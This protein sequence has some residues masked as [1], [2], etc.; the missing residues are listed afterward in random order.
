MATQRGVS[1]RASPFEP[2]E[3]R[4]L[5]RSDVVISELVANNQSGLFDFF[6]NDSDWFEIHNRESSHVN[7][8]GWHVTDDL[9]NLTKWQ[10]PVTTILAPD[11]RRVVFASEQDL[12]TAT[13]E[14]HTNFRLSELGE[15]LALVD[16]DG[17]VVDS[18]DPMFPSQARDVSYG[19][20]EGDVTALIAAGAPASAFVP[21]NDSLGNS[22]TGANE[23]F[24]ENN[25]IS[26]TSGI[27]YETGSVSE[28][29]VPPV[30]YWTF[31]AL[32]ADGKIAPDERGMYHG[33][34]A[35]ATLTTEHA[36]RF[37]EA[38]ALDGDDDYVDV[39]VVPEL[40]NPAAM[41]VSL[42]FRHTVD[43][44]GDVDDMNHQVNNVLIGH[45]S[46]TSNDT[47]EIG[48][49]DDFIE[50][51]LD[52]EQLGGSVAPIREQAPLQN[53]VWHHLVMT[54]DSQ[55][56]T[57]VKLYL[58][59]T[60]EVELSEWGG[61]ISDSGDSP[62]SI[63]LARPNANAWGDFEGLIDDVAIWD[64]A[65]DGAQ[66]SAL[67]SGTSPLLL[68]GFDSL[69]GL[70][71]AAAML[72]QNSSAYMRMPF[73]VTDPADMDM[74][75]LLL[76]YDDAFVAYINGQEVA[77]A[78]FTGVPHWNSVADSDRPNI[79]ALYSAV[80]EI[81]VQPGILQTGKN[82]LA[83]QGMNATVASDRFL[84]LPELSVIAL[85]ERPYS[86]MRTPTPGTI[87]FAGSVGFAQEP[88]LSVLG[89]M[90][91]DSFHLELTAGSLDAEIRYTTNGSLPSETSN[92][93]IGP[94][95]ING[96]MQIRAITFRPDYIRSEIVSE[97]YTKLG[98]D[99]VDYQGSGQA[100]NSQVPLVVVNTFGRSIIDGIFTN[101]SFA[102]FDKQNGSASLANDV[103][104]ESRA[105]LKIRGRGSAGLPKSPYALE[106]RQD[107][108]DSDRSISL[109]VM[110]AEADWVFYGPYMT[111]RSMNRNPLMFD[112]SNQVGRYASRTAYVEVFVNQTGNLTFGDYVGIY[113]LTEK[114][115]RDPERVDVDKL[116]SPMVNEPDITGGYIFKQDR[117]DQG[118]F[119]IA[120]AGTI[121]AYVEPK[122]IE[123]LQRPEQEAYLKNYLNDFFS[124][125]TSSDFTHPS[126]GQNYSEL[127]DIVAAVD[128]H[129]LNE[130]ALNVDAF[131]LSAFWH[132][133]RNGKLQA[134]PIWDLDLSIE[135]TDDRDDDPTTWYGPG[136]MPHFWL[137]MFSDL[138]FRQAYV[139]R[140]TEFRRDMFSDENI[141]DTIDRL[142]S[143]L[144][145]DN[146][147]TGEPD[148]V[149]RNFTRWPQTRPRRSS[150]YNSGKLN[151]TFRGELEHQKVW[152]KERTA[153]LDS[154]FL[155][156]P[157]F[158]KT[159][160]LFKELQTL[161]ITVPAGTT[162]YYTIDGTDPRLPG[163]G[164]SPSATVYNE[165]ILISDTL[166]I[167]AR[168][169]D[170]GYNV[171]VSTF[172]QPVNDAEAWS[173]S[174]ATVFR[175]GS[176][177]VT[178]INYHPHEPTA[179]ELF[180]DPTFVD[181]DFEFLELQNT[182]Q[183]ILTL[184]GMQLN[185]GIDFDFS[186]SN[187]T[188]LDPGDYALVVRNM[189]AFVTR[190]GAGLREVV[191]GQY[192][193]SLANGGEQLTLVD[194]LNHVLQRFDYDDQ[195][196]WSKLPD[197]FGGTLEI[198]DPLQDLDDAVNWRAS[199]EF[200]GTPGTAGIGV[201]ASVVINEVLTNPS[202]GED[203][204]ELYN[205][206]SA[207]VD[208]SGW[209]LSDSPGNLHRFVF[210]ANST[211]PAGSFLVLVRN[212]IGF[213]LD[214][215]KGDDVVLVQPDALGNP[216]QFIDH[217]TFGAAMSDESFGRWPNESGNVYP[218]LSSTFGSA[219]LGPRIGP[220]VVGEIMYNPVSTVDDPRMLEFVEIYN[221]TSQSVG[222]SG[223]TLEGTGFEFPSDA[224]IGPGQTLVL[225][226]FNPSTDVE[227][228]SAF[229]ESYGVTLLSNLA[230][231]LG[232]YPGQLADGGEQLTL[233]R[234]LN[235]P[236]VSPVIEDQVR[237]DNTVPWPTSPDGAGA[238]LQRTRVDLW[239]NDASSWSS[240]A[241]TPGHMGPGRIFAWN[242]SLPAIGEVGKLNDLTHHSQTVTLAG[243]YAN[244]VV[245][246][247]PSSF[248][249]TDPVVVRVSNVQPNQFDISVV[250]P[251]NQNG[252]HNA[253]ETVSYLVLEA[254]SH[255]LRDGTHLEVGT[256]TTA[257]TVG[258]QLVAPNW[259]T[260]HLTTTFSEPPVV[261]S[262]VLTLHGEA[263]L[264]TRQR[265]VL[266]H[267]FELALEQEELSATQHVAET[268]GYLAI[269]GG[270]GIW[271]GMLFEAATT[272]S[273]FTDLFTK[274]EFEQE[275]FT[276][277]SFLA[278]LA[279]HNG[280]DVGHL[281]FQ[282]LT[283]ESVQLKVDEDT[284]F[285]PET[286][287]S[288]SESVMY[289]T[290][291]GEGLVTAMTKSV[292]DGA[293]QSLTLLVGETGRMIDVDVSFELVHTRPEDLVLSLEAPDGT[294][295]QLLSNVSGDGNVSR[296]VLDDEALKPISTAE[297]PWFGR[298]HPQ[299]R[300]RDFVGQE[301]QGAWTLHV[302]DEN[303]NG[304]AGA[305]I[306]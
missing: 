226:P 91:A 234:G 19:L 190:Y 62:L 220:L 134:G 253:A 292:V 147:S 203:A 144:G 129:L 128:H 55:N 8:E 221:P 244:P 136:N 181:S 175:V 116:S 145:S 222:L 69:I 64:V 261:L 43:H 183:T 149:T 224:V 179:E 118:E 121:F 126:T 56:L 300:L 278:S 196:E 218:M 306:T 54:Y 155:A 241:P 28:T 298:F 135:S 237:F 209:W 291:E 70:D 5:L 303:T 176:I 212:D 192:S 152:L 20:E 178:E 148:S 236:E 93:Y 279:S 146:P 77:R 39:G 76:N 258:P 123:I 57:E 282:D 201:L 102:V 22:W 194:E 35:G 18:F 296:F 168:S 173:G 191:A 286:G 41:S 295:V 275:Y 71:L 249:G 132:K 85:P 98:A 58:D 114:I 38:L 101:I 186:S 142:A 131:R 170:G 23:P 115:K 86:F 73:Y 107:H 24:D 95:V 113:V 17:A 293:T 106:L 42:W 240:G 150:A 233:R 103:T 162:V 45:S 174:A 138:E 302:I 139:D 13:G 200:S 87:N 225:V 211:I 90:F 16:P 105:A 26:G 12:V 49:E 289:M 51:Y 154:L 110:P 304:D 99:L 198:I 216:G 199:T 260:V 285:D 60:L 210:P 165:P 257:A 32:E 158:D 37:G 213:G 219:N 89:G 269:D 29:I 53:N 169:F 104:V 88:S 238:S 180:L 256:V 34:V 11:E 100:F 84:I 94:I 7:L 193:G 25:W 14:F 229:E 125:V 2:L 204:F 287:H 264:S 195:D 82:I 122:E 281:R 276:T 189:S 171:P 166:R 3:D 248:V 205:P 111:D 46:T 112:L 119:G 127:M 97:T 141:V 230:S 242:D 72:N 50:V 21:S 74:L 290:I 208:I 153:W 67:F 263:Y 262:Q 184:D 47:L 272:S 48:M 81:T 68:S 215:G 133:P 63:G 301:V 10:V 214:G 143:E 273:Q 277:P 274:L 299:G 96:T 266:E 92:L 185:E 280:R 254:G 9:A 4:I 265:A 267:E 163:G 108:D 124:A 188:S 1:R 283:P 109:L 44:A 182:G 243:T 36:G 270:S 31:D 117:L 78:D 120:A 59:G 268:V 65:L 223:W 187:V 151:G 235:P 80:F 156:P 259:E 250:E 157:T 161:N 160:G 284:T 294:I 75:R 247:Q 177:S 217:V 159:G 30:A 40:V 255:W 207:T 140:W 61:L 79:A 137:Y 66:V 202:I 245:L 252:L 6:D 52:T 227:H 246:A 167:T 305:V 172:D 15:P 27:G 239:G 297:T 232:P 251:S 231:Y 130:L 197:G 206:T 271:N 228:R 288:A 164:I 83:L 33:F